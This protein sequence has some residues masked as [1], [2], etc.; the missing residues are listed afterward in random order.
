MKGYH[1]LISCTPKL[2]PAKI[3]K[4]IEGRS[5]RLLQKEFP[6]LEKRYWGRHF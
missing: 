6:H 1:I 2:S 4:R 5:S 3:M